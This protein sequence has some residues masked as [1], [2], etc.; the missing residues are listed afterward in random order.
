MLAVVS[1]LLISHSMLC[2]SFLAYNRRDNQSF[3]NYQD[4]MLLLQQKEEGVSVFETDAF[5][6]WHTWLAEGDTSGD[7]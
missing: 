6:G 2:T 3:D 1:L 5:P 7:G 4:Y